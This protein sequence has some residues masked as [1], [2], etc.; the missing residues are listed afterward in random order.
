M[1]V[2]EQTRDE[3]IAMYLKL[4]E[5][6]LAE[7][8]VNANEALVMALERPAFLPATADKLRRCPSP[9]IPLTTTTSRVHYGCKTDWNGA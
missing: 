5:R 6:E 3:Q 2:I 9:S 8:L 7:M 4:T 1:S